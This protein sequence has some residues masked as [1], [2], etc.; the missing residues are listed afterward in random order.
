MNTQPTVLKMQ[1]AIVDPSNNTIQEEASKVHQNNA[2]LAGSNLISPVK[3]EAE[4][5][6]DGVLDPQNDKKASSP[7]R[8]PEEGGDDPASKTP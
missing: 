1:T 3:L 4:W 6:L 5:E 7:T 2:T 8:K